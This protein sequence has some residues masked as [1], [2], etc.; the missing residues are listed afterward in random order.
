MIIITISQLIFLWH[1][2]YCVASHL[3]PTVSGVFSCSDK[4]MSL[5]PRGVDNDMWEWI[6]GADQWS[7]ATHVNVLAS[8]VYEENS[9]RSTT[10]LLIGSE[11]L[12]VHSI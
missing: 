2:N 11:C 4:G 7:K 3:N 8:G 12:S 10:K 6:S 5:S 1:L 9:A